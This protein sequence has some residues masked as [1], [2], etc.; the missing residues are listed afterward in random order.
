MDNLE[1]RLVSSIKKHSELAAKYRAVNHS[2]G[3]IKLEKLVEVLEGIWHGNEVLFLPPLE[4]GLSTRQL[5]ARRERQ[6]RKKILQDIVAQ[7]KAGKSCMDCGSNKVNLTFDHRIRES[8]KFDIAGCSG[9]TNKQMHEEI[10]K[11]DLVCRPCHNKREKKRDREKIINA[12]RNSK[13]SN[14]RQYA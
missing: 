11:C 4:N 5:A 14:G 7:A 6:N 13:V 9:V 2:D 3:A 8:K 10:A 1:L 12:T